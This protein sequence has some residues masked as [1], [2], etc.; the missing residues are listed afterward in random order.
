MRFFG[1]LT[2][3]AAMASSVFV[4][5]APAPVAAVPA[6]VARVPEPMPFA[7]ASALAERGGCDCKDVKSILLD[8]EIKVKVHIAV[9]GKC[10][11]MSLGLLC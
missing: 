11:V 2:L 7:E 1:A 4:A 5:A 9:L 3:V 10:I 8:L 6:I